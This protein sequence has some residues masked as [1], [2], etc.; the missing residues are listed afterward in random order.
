[1]VPRQIKHEVKLA[2]L[3]PSARILETVRLCGA[4]RHVP[5]SCLNL[6]FGWISDFIEHEVRL[7][8]HD[9]FAHMLGQIAQLCV[10]CLT[11]FF[12]TLSLK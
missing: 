11:W 6:E 1:M 10:I 4:L 9:T 2:S 5:C 3:L 8:N 7:A 12:A